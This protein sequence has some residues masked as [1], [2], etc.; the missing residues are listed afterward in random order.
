VATEL[1]AG[2]HGRVVI[3]P[4]GAVGRYMSLGNAN[5]PVVLRPCLEEAEMV[6]GHITPARSEAL[7]RLDLGSGPGML[8][9]GA[10][11]PE[12]FGPDQ[13]IDLLT[14]TAGVVQR[15]LVGHL[16]RGD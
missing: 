10:A 2:L 7:M 11:D 14:F 4:E 9:F 8:A 16:A 1:G 3:L 6:F 15:L 12:R 13:G 5:G